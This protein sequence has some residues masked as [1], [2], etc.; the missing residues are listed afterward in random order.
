MVREEAVVERRQI[1]LEEEGVEEAAGE[2]QMTEQ[3]QQQS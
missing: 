3:Q 1:G 2:L